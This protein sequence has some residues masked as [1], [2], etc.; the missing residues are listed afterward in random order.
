MDKEVFRELVKFYG[1]AFNL[2]P[3][4][5]KIYAYLIFD[6]NRKGVAFDEFV[7]VFAVSKSSVSSN[8]NLL[9][10]LNLIRDFNKIDE[11]KRFFVVN[12]N[13][14]KIRFQEILAR[15]KK[16]LSLMDQL[17]VIAAAQD[18]PPEEKHNICR[19]FFTENIKSLQETIDKLP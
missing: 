18:Q 14:M 17:R 2:P 13:Y 19:E 16:E 15:M 8:I 6:F 9:L 11:R 12:Q 1:E 5:A 4:A 3:L 7:D 10:N